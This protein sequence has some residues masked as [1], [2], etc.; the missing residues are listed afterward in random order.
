MQYLQKLLST[1]RKDHPEKPT[2]ASPPIDSAPLMARPTVKPTTKQKRGQQAK[3]NGAKKR[4]KKS[5]TFDFYLVFGP[6][7]ILPRYSAKR[8]SLVTYPSP[9]ATAFSALP[10]QFFHLL[11]FSPET[12]TRPGGFFLPM[13]FHDCSAD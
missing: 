3:A 8:S 13:Q 7:L 5:W 2:A 10:F 12:S 6:V 9:P 11:V 4:A 1:F